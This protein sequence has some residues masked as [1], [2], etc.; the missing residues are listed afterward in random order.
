[1]DGTSLDTLTRDEKWLVR[2]AYDGGFTIIAY[3]VTERD[4]IKLYRDV[5]AHPITHAE[6]A[7]MDGIP[8]GGAHAIFTIEQHGGV[9]WTSTVQLTSHDNLPGGPA[10]IGR[11]ESRRIRRRQFQLSPALTAGLGCRR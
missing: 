7:S 5:L 1:M 8:E 4:I 3:D 6:L 11:V 2:T 10:D 9:D